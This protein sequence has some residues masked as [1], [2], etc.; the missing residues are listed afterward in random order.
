MIKNLVLVAL[1]NFKKDKG[2]SLIN[3]LGLTIGITFSLLLLFYVMDELSYDRYH[4]KNDRIHRI[5]SYVK[6]P[7]NNM[8][9][10]NTQFPLAPALKKDYPEVEQSARFINADRAMYKNGELQFY[11]NKIFYADSN[12]FEIFTYNFL[13]GDPETALVAPNS[14]VL[15]QSLAEKY[16][17]KGKTAAGQSLQ[18]NRGDVYK[19]T[20]VVKDV[21]KNSHIIFNGLLSR[22]TLPA[23]FSDNWGS[24]GFFTYVL[25]RPNTNVSAFEK[26]LLPMYDKYMAPIFAQYNINIRYGT[27]PITSI[28]LHSDM[29][30]EPEELGSMSYIY[31]FSS[32]ALFMLII[33]CINYMNLATARSARRAKEIGIRKTMG[34]SNLQVLYLLLSVFGKLLLISSIIAIPVAYYLTSQWLQSFEYRTPLTVMVFGGAIGMIALITLVTVGY[35]SLKAS[36]SNPVNSLRHE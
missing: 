9:W 35:E 22:S 11:E 31:I 6:E 14:M 27:Q 21:P 24:F 13:Q 33:A 8:K 30:G 15:T 26:K 32:V 10:A 20:A 28:H 23:D 1:R 3:I 7:G 16:F 17:G 25:L 19:I 4:T 34:A 29:T 36:L 5:V 18:N 2:Y 12:L